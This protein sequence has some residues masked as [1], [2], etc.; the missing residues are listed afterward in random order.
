MSIDDRWVWPI[1]IFLVG[2]LVIIFLVF[3]GHV[4]DAVKECERR[5][6]EWVQQRNR[7]GTV[8]SSKCMRDLP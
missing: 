4:K 6:G 7:D 1:T 3:A 2:M 5:G 8:V